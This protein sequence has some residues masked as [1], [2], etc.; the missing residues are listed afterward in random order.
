[1]QQNCALMG[2]NGG[3]ANTSVAPHMVFL[4]QAGKVGTKLWKGNVPCHV[5]ACEVRAV[6]HLQVPGGTCGLPGVCLPSE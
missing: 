3:T 6:A 2:G 1:M 5:G 4:S